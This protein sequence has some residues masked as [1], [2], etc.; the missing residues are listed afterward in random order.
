MTRPTRIK[1]MGSIT[2]TKRTVRTDQ[3]AKVTAQLMEAT[4]RLIAEGSSFTEL[5][6]EKLSQEAGIARSTYYMHF[7]DKG[8]LIQ[9]LTR[10]ITGELM[11][12]T[13]RWWSVAAEATR[14]QLQR[15]ML[16]TLKIY[17]RHQ[18]VFGSLAETA[19]YDPEV[20]RAFDGLLKVMA[21][22][23]LDAIRTGQRSGTIRKEV[24]E[25]SFTALVWM[26]ER[27]AYRRVRNGSD[28]DLREAAAIVT[29]VIWQVLYTRG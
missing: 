17:R 14:P 18:A 27:I 11:Q 6:V 8:E 1:P 15:A 4:E 29:D 5:S 7:K 22:H 9:A 28:K 10:N 13:Q 21:S 3:R 20:S 2:R 12:A 19:S 16:E 26:T 24:T 25:A 23:S